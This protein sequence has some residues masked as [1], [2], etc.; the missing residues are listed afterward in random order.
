MYIN[1]DY[2]LIKQKHCREMRSVVDCTF[3]TKTVLKDQQS[4][5]F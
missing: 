2:I 1:T 4:S 5:P 3:S